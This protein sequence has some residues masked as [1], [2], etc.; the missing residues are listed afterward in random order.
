MLVKRKKKASIDELDGVKFT[1]ESENI[2]YTISKESDENLFKVS[3]EKNHINDYE[4]SV[5]YLR[6]EIVEKIKRGVWKIVC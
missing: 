2:V 5:N 1:H 3:W 4:G 6:E